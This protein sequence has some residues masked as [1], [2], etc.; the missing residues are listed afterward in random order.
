MMGTV[1]DPIIDDPMPDETKEV[2]LDAPQPYEV[3]DGQVPSIVE[4]RVKNFQN[5]KAN[6]VRAA[7][8][9]ARKNRRRNQIARKSRR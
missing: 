9:R 3:M 4:Q 7:K 1:F 6:R 5:E 2:L 8:N